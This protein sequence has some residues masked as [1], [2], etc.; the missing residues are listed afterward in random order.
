MNPMAN[1]SPMGGPVGGAPVPMMNN[2]NINPQAANA[3]NVGN[4]GG[5]PRGQGPPA[6]QRAIFNTYIYEYFIRSGMF[7]CARALLNAEVPVL[8]ERESAG[9]RR[10]ENG[11]GVDDP[12]DT[13]SKEDLDPK[14]PDNLPAP[15]LPSGP[16]ES[17]LYEWFSIFLDI[18]NANRGKGSNGVANQYVAHAQVWLLSFVLPRRFTCPNDSI[19]PACFLSLF[20]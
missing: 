17:F 13:D 16:S 8:V 7:D 5:A 6:D 19:P 20:H 10:D 15:K 18:Y 3:A 1:M 2:G 11:N 12:M 14:L 4:L 9:R